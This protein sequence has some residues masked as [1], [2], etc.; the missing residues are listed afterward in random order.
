VTESPID[1]LE[2]WETQ[3]AQWR[4]AALGDEHVSIDLCA[5]TGEVVDRLDSDDPALIE[6]VRGRARSDS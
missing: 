1:T 5:C 4:V 3:G 6:Y 2:R